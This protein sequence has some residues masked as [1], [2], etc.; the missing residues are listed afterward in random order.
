MAQDLPEAMRSNPQGWSI[1]D[2]EALCGSAG[3]RC[4][5]PKRGSHYKVSHP[6]QEDILT[7]PARRPIKPFYIRKLVR[8]V[9]KVLTEENQR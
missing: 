8:F 2:V 6:S 9:G 4:R 3:I 1:D 5:P 7:I